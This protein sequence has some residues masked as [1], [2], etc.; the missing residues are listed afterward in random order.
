LKTLLIL[1]AHRGPPVTRSSR[2][3]SELHQLLGAYFICLGA[4]ARELGDVF[5]ATADPV[6]PEALADLLA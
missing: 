5:T 3:A 6:S 1:S 4:D 2:D